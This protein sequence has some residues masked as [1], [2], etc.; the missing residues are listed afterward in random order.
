[1]EGL[2]GWKIKALTI[3]GGNGNDCWTESGGLYLG[4]GWVSYIPSRQNQV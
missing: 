4:R 3:D 2:K 1:M